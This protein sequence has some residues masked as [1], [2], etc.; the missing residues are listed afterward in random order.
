MQNGVVV[1]WV[2][3]PH[4]AKRWVGMDAATMLSMPSLGFAE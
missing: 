2:A 1:G 4:D 3:C